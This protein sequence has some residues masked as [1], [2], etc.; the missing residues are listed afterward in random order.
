M[1]VRGLKI[2]VIVMGVMLIVGVVVL[3]GAIGARVSH[4][5]AEPPSRPAF[6]ADPIELP[7]GARIESMTAGSDRLVLD[8]L[9]ADGTRQLL[10]LDL[11]SGRRLGTIPLRT[12]P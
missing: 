11:A 2:A 5:S 12:A 4:K 3:I 8:V 6:A 7:A 9:L 1:P 10:I